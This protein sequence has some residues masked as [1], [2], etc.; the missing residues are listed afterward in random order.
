M[1]NNHPILYTFRRCPYAI[2]ARLALALSQ[3]PYIHREVDLKNKPTA[4]LEIATKGTVPILQLPDQKI[5]DE[6][7]DILKWTQTVAPPG[8]ALPGALDAPEHT[9]WLLSLHETYIPALNRF[10]YPDRY[11]DLLPATAYQKALY[12]W[13]QILDQA[14]LKQPHILSTQPN[15][16]EIAIYPF[17]R[18]TRIANT[19]WL[20]N[21]GL[22]A[23]LKWLAYWDH[24]LL[25]TNTMRKIPVWAP[26]DTPA[27]IQHAFTLNT[28]SNSR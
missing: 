13:L 24:C 17:I 19:Q 27:L 20:E 28:P 14:L 8:N 4:M 25:Q 7:L 9:P 26:G 2:R 15:L 12:T 21:C 10:K 3:I 11:E 18:Q 22:H 1:A 16:L 6:S 23:M 5:I